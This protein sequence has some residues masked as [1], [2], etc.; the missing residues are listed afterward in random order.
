MDHELFE[1]TADQQRAFKR[2][3]KAYRDCE[4]SGILF[5]N[6]YG[7]LGAVDSEK[8][9]AYNDQYKPGCLRNHDVYNF[10]TLKIVNE[11]TDDTH[12]FHP[13]K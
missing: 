4:Q 10:N 5:Y 11:W 6:C 8:I 9:V 13:K 7:S 2:L 12:Y 1:L 3:K